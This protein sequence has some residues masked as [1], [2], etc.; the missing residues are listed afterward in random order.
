MDYTLKKLISKK[1]AADVYGVSIRTIER[2]LASG[3]LTKI[4]IRGCVRVKLSEIRAL[5]GEEAPA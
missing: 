1:D 2:M 5:L 4:K 3:Q